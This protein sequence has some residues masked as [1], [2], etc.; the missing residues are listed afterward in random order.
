MESHKSEDQGVTKDYR[1]LEAATEGE[2]DERRRPVRACPKFL[3]AILQTG[4][5]EQIVYIGDI[6]Y[7]GAKILNAPP[8]LK[9]GDTIKLATCLPGRDVMTIQCSIAYAN[10]NEAQSDVGVRFLDTADADTRALI[11]Y[12]CELVGEQ[13]LNKDPMFKV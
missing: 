9:A 10:G 11:S 1:F 3:S 8:G 5:D 7:A 12:L 6:S 2:I 13:L 4:E